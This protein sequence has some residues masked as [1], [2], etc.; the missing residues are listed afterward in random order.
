MFALVQQSDTCQM[1]MQCSHIRGFV[2]LILSRVI[3]NIKIGLGFRT[4]SKNWQ[5]GD[6]EQVDI[7]T[8]T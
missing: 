4:S 5:L 3:T 8:S 6:S 7:H 1:S 2:R